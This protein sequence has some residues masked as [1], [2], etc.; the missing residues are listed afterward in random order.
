[1]GTYLHLFGLA[2]DCNIDGV[3][4]IGNRFIEDKSWI[5]Q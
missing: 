4:S 2:H 5:S 3:V 1:M